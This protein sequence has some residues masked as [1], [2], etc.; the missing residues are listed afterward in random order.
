M[1]FTYYGSAPQWYKTDNIVVSVSP[2]NVITP[3]LIDFSKATLISEGKIKVLTAAEKDR[4]R[5]EHMQIAPELIEGTHPQSVKSDIYSLGIVFASIYKFTKYKPIK[6]LAK[7]SLMPFQTR[8][9]S[10]EILAI[11]MDLMKVWFTFLDDFNLICLNL[12]PS[13]LE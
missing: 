8:C 2:V 12:F 9:T 11:L 1:L 4:Y 5:K 10:S 3:I 13:Y 7:K 6:E